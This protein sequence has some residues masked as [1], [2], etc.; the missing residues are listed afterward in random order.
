[1]TSSSKILKIYFLAHPHGDVYHDDLIYLGEGLKQLGHDLH[2]NRN[3]WKESAESP[4]YLI[5]HDPA[6]RADQADLVIIA[7]QYHS[8][9]DPRDFL[10][11][12]APIPDDL[13]LPGPR[14]TKRVLADENDGWKT[15]S[16]LPWARRM[17]LCLRVKLNKR[18]EYPDNLR[19]W[20]LGFTS[21]ILRMGALDKPFDTRKHAVLDNF[22]FSHPYAHGVRDWARKNVYPQLPKSLPVEFRMASRCTEKDGKWNWLM[23]QQT[24]GKHNPAYY[25]NLCDYQIVSCFCGD[26][27]PSKPLDASKMMV[28]GRKA[29][30]RRT[31]YGAWDNLTGA[32]PRL[33][34][35]DSWRFWETLVCGAVALHF[36][37]EKGGVLLP[38]M[39][40]PGVHYLACDEH[41][42]IPPE[43]LRP[44]RLEQI[45]IQGRAWALEHYAPEVA[46]RRL[47]DWLKLA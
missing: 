24:L 34:Q 40:V 44:D 27:C 21:R 41:G 29:R 32:I 4:D 36:D 10:V 8:Y 45:A 16:W 25:Q 18:C 47:I 26:W 28:G 39:P 42:R 5:P 19:P 9:T 7:G 31:I 43:W 17:D 30:I 35:W 2:G 23:Y 38:V 11:R 20:V 6:V 13:L 15:V 3:L 1:V 46:A 22:G 14:K 12:S 33:I 37:L